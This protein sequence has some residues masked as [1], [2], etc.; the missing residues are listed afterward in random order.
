MM[1]TA[2]AATHDLR[3]TAPPDFRRRG[4]P[5]LRPSSSWRE[6][7][8]ASHQNSLA[9]ELLHRG[10]GSI[11]G[12]SGYDSVHGNAISAVQNIDYGRPVKPREH[13]L[14]RRQR[15]PRHVRHQVSLVT[16]GEH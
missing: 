5:P 14:D 10:D 9:T 15:S 3:T 13:S 1:R 4:S 6:P 12:I 16:R 8:D 2:P 11:D 7:L